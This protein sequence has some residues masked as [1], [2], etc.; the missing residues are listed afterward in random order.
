MSWNLSIIHIKLFYPSFTISKNHSYWEVIDRYLNELHPF[1][2]NQLFFLKEKRKKRQIGTQISI[3]WEVPLKN[4]QLIVKPMFFCSLFYVGQNSAG[5][6]LSHC[7]FLSHRH[8]AE[9]ILKR[10]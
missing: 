1:F 5:S 6:Y 2:T 7:P 9:S 4:L 3:N 8:Y 10:F